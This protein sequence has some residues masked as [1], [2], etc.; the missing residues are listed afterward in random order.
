MGRPALVIFLLM[1][2]AVLLTTEF[3]VLDVSSRISTDIVKV[4]W[5]R[6]NP[7][8]T[9]SRLYYVFLWTTI[10]LGSCILLLGMVG[11]NVSAFRLFKFTAAMNGGVMFLYSALLLVVNGRRLPTGIRMPWWRMLIIAWAVL[12]FGFFCCWATMTAIQ[13]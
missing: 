7:R 12:F 6:E 3:G 13:K 11:V 2:I 5:L 10:G 4:T 8:W 9:E 1:G